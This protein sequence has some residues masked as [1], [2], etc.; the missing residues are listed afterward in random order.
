LNAPAE[1]EEPP[2]EEE[3]EEGAKAKPKK[4]IQFT[5]SSDFYT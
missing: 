1:E 2:A 5:C 4:E 3:G